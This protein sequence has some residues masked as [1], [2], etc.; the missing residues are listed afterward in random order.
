MFPTSH[1][2]DRYLE[3]LHCRADFSVVNLLIEHITEAI[4]AVSILSCDDKA[5]ELRLQGVL[6]GTEPKA[7]WQAQLRINFRYKT[8]TQM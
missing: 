2:P 1:H 5:V 6:L 3:S 7:V 8:K 4:A